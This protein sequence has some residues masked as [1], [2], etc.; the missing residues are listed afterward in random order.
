MTMG[1]ELPAN[2]TQFVLIVALLL[3]FSHEAQAGPFE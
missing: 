1:L 2:L 3:I